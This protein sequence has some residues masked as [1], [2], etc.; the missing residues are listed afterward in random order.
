DVGRDHA[1]SATFLWPTFLSAALGGRAGV[2]PARVLAR[3]RCAA[4][5]SA[6]P[7]P[8]ATGVLAA[9]RRHPARTVVPARSGRGATAAL[10]AGPR[11]PAGLRLGGGIRSAPRSHEPGWSAAGRVRPAVDRLPAGR[12]DRRRRGRG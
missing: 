1:T 6:R 3:P 8:G 12:A 7:R 4:A 11:R 9:A 5:L 2:G 10:P